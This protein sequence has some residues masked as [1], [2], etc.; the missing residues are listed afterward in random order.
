MPVEC[1]QTSTVPWCSVADSS[2]PI[3]LFVQTVRSR[4]RRQAAWRLSGAAFLVGG[5]AFLGLLVV[6]GWWSSALWRPLALVGALAG[7]ATLLVARAR[8]RRRVASDAAVA[9]LVGERLPSLGDDLWSAIELSRELPKL[10]A[11]PV[12]SG[13]LVRAL[14]A[15]VSA[16]LGEID[17]ARIVD[18]APARRQALRRMAAVA[19]LWLLA[20]L[21]RPSLLGRGWRELADSGDER[22]T[23]SAEPIVGDLRVTLAFPAYTGLGTR[24]VDGLS[25]QLLILPG[26]NV[27]VEAQALVPT[28]GAAELAVSEDGR[29]PEMRPVEVS[30]QSLKASFTMK[31]AGSFRFVLGGG[32]RRLREPQAH[33]VEIDPD[34]PP[35]VDLYTPGDPLEVAGP[36]R[37]ELAYSIDDDYGLHDVDLVWS[38]G[39]SAETRKKVLAPKDGQRA[40]SGRFEWDLGELDLQPGAHVAYHLEA[41]DNDDVS[42]PNVGRSRTFYLSMSSPHEKRERAVGLE[43]QLLEVAVIQLGDRL[44]VK[45]DEEAFVELLVPIHNRAE[46]LVV[47]LAQAEQAAETD[48]P[49]GDG[50]KQLAEI[51]GRLSKLVRDEEGMLGEVRKRRPPHGRALEGENAKL[52]TELERDVIALDDLLGRQRLEEL[53]RVGDEMT[54]A[55]DRLKQLLAEYKKSHSEAVKKEIEREIRELERKL[56][57]L[58]QRAQKLASDMP[59]QFLNPDAMGK[60]DLQSRLDKMRDLLQRGDVDAAMAELDRLSSSLDK[61]MS[62]MERDLG[63]YRRDRFSEEEKRLAELEEKVADLEH[64]EKQLQNETGG[65]QQRTRAEGQRQMRDKVE[66]YIKR[67]RDKTAQLKKHLEQVDKATLSVW[68]QEELGRIKQRAADLDRMLGE[69]DLDEARNAARTSENGLRALSGDLADDEARAWHGARPGLKK[70]REHLDDGEKLARELADE[71]DQI[72]PRPDQLMSPEDQKRMP[73]LAERQKA[74]KKRASEL[75]RELESPQKGSGKPRLSEG[76]KQAG[77]HMDRA[78]GRLRTHDP[79]DAEGEEQ[80]AVDQLGQLKQQLQRERRPREQQMGERLDKEPVKI[81]GADEYR[82]PREFRQDLLEAMKRAAPAEY[83]DQVKRYYEELVK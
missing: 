71:M 70:A 38:V 68:E 50:K 18:A 42:G 56:A 53:L 69:G 75:Q 1:D 43:E 5:S 7:A 19:S 31:R 25:G 59:D 30:G 82:A 37:V 29:A 47:M 23:T 2:D 8:L 40:A 63:D 52:V 54:H 57:E 27:A 28:R 77:Q 41:R 10:E 3:D 12:L 45:H 35:R 67:A 6:A 32:L 11:E 66:P 4:A 60:N 46:A 9:R 33:R 34:R 48:K 36:R 81:P 78:E 22:L 74:M 13:E 58:K 55:R 65:I 73:E 80:Q 16:R 79:R 21:L 39:E 49:D 83:K 72:M 76:I 14:R 62:S 26:T 44:E 17:P 20:A 64:D 15:N 24:V 51:H 61:M